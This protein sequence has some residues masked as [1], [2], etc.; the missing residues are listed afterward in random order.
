VKGTVVFG[1]EGG[2]VIAVNADGEIQWRRALG[3]SLVGISC[4]GGQIVAAGAKGLLAGL[5]G[6]GIVLWRLESGKGL[7]AAPMTAG[8]R[9]FVIG[10]DG[11]LLAVDS[12]RGAASSFPIGTTGAAV[13]ARNGMMYLGGRDWIFYAIGNVM[14]AGTDAQGQNARGAAYAGTW[15]QP[16]HDEM[17]SGRTEAAPPAGNESLLSSLPD[18]LYIQ[19]LASGNRDILLRLLSEIRSRI[20]SDSLGKSTWYVVRQLEHLVG[21]GVLDPVYQNM[22]LVNDFPEVRAEAAA[23]LGITGSLGSRDVLIKVIGAEKES[24]ALAAEIDALGMI[25]SDADGASARA[26]AEA[27]FRGET[28]DNLVAA[29]A[30]FALDR[31]AAYEGVIKDPAAISALIRIS[32]GGFSRKVR[33]G[34]LSVLSHMGE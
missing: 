3:V 19:S 9:L 21:E 16:G 5:S 8:S 27:V 25:G 2:E 28:P 6:S 1:T 4:G 7:D 23:L 15:P 32:R 29:A 33:D 34:A 30:V 13:L 17:H 11:V 24:M 26:V 10:S 12:A 22:K 31:L 14:E 20:V 18:Y